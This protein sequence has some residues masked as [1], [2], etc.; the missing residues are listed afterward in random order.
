MKRNKT[1]RTL[2]FVFAL[3]LPAWLNVQP[4]EWDIFS[5]QQEVVAEA[6]VGI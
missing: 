6:G 1:R 3:F 2:F 4:K 5:E